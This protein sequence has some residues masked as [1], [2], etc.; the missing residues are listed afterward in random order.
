[1][2]RRLVLSLPLLTVI[3][4]LGCSPQETCDHGEEL[5]A[6]G[7]CV[8]SDRC[9][10]HGHAH[11]D[12]CHCDEGFVDEGGICVAGD[13]HDHGDEACGDHGHLHGDTCHCDEGYVAEGDTCVEA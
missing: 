7:A 6:S 11:G 9:G 13:E 12:T 1:M 10:E 4:S 8:R 3:W 5:D 2:L